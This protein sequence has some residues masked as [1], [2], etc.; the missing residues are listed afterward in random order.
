MYHD[1][2]KSS[3]WPIDSPCLGGV[4]NPAQSAFQCE[5]PAHRQET[6]QLRTRARKNIS[7]ASAYSREQIEQYEEHV[8]LPT[9]FRIASKPALDVEYL[10]ALHVYQVSAVP[11]ENLTLHYSATHV[12]S[13]DP[14]DLF[15]KIVADK[16]GRGGYCM[17]C[18]IFFN[19]ILRALG[20]QVY[21]AGVRVRPRVGGVPTGD[22]KGWY[23]TT[24]TSWST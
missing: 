19:H 14:Q 21:T 12:P 22:Y 5:H 9:K 24:S 17:E 2:K 4:E 1:I 8:D 3:K 6:G 20:F 10:T 16:R 18:S 7:M 15:K 13:L 23:V 11:Y